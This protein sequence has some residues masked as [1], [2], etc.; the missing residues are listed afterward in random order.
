MSM[1]CRHVL[2][3][4][5]CVIG[6]AIAVER[7]LMSVKLMKAQQIEFVVYGD[8]RFTA[9][10][11]ISASV[12]GARR[13]LV[14]RI[15]ALK[16][17]AVLLTGDVPWHG[18]TLDDYAVYQFETKSWRSAA[19]QVFPALGNHEFSGCEESVCLENWWRTFPE[20]RGHR[21]Y[22]VALGSRV[23]AIALD[24]DASLAADSPQRVWLDQQLS[25]MPRDVQFVIV[26]LH[27][28]PV[29]DMAT[30]LLA[31][32]NPRPNELE[33][34]TDLKARAANTRQ[35]YVV[36]G[37][38]I[39]NYARFLQDNV[40]YLV[41][42]GGG[43]KAYPVKRSEQDLYL[44][45]DA[46]NFHFLRFY[47]KKDVLVAEMVRLTDPYTTHPHDFEVAD[48]FELRAH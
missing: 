21:W 30:G 24:S 11:E 28:P 13:A 12:P 8:M 37:G 42:G 20:L 10:T 19:L 16:P 15:A 18:G 34:A 35:R 4:L 29:A 43:A 44:R 31:S 27:H 46:A 3:F 48:R 45:Q 38:H 47:L 6:N 25:A 26:Y 36:V 17:Q 39:H 1:Q 33:L 5:V 9:P 32:H 40:V 14:E 41:S 7:P 2:W 22:E 23:H